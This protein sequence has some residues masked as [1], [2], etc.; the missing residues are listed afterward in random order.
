M[1]FIKQTLMVVISAMAITSCI[2]V[3]VNDEHLFSNVIYAA[4]L[5]ITVA[6]LYFYHYIAVK[7][8]IAKHGEE[9]G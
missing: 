8:Q 4:S 9:L 6:L 2:K 3:D 7:R 5:L 1:K